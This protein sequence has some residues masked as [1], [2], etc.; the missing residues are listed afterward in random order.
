MVISRCK[1][2]ESTSEMQY[3]HDKEYGF[4]V[5]DNVVIFERLMLEI[6]QAGLTWKLILS[7]REGFNKAFHNYK[8]HK[9]A[10]MT[11]RELE[12]QRN[13]PDIVRNK[14]K[15]ETTRHNAKLCIKIIEE[16]GSLIKYFQSLP[17]TYST[18]DELKPTVKIMKKDGFKF[19][20]P[21]ILE[22]FFLSI[23][24]NKVKHE[25]TCF[26]YSN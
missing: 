25:K 8:I 16:H 9:V 24:I 26:L 23:G 22:E 18:L 19:I 3:Y 6:Y 12:K 11:D 17:H 15:I 5:S 21:L 2:A 4:P 13:N 7:K 14:L 20:G 1:W 10:N